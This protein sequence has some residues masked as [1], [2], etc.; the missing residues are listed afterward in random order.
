MTSTYHSI[1]GAMNNVWSMVGQPKHINNALNRLSQDQLIQLSDNIRDIFKNSEIL[2]PPVLC[3]IGSQSSGKSITLNGL[4]GI[5]ILPNGKS[6]V[7]RTPIHLRLIHTKDSKIIYVDFFDN[8]DNQ[9]II[10]SFQIDATQTSSKDHNDQLIPIRDEIMKLTEQRAGRSKNVV[11]VPIDIRIRS[12]DVPNLSIIDLPGLTNIALTDE[13][14]PENIKE[15]IEQ[16]LIRYIKNPRTIILSI[17]PATID[18]ESDMGLGLIKTY[19]P[20]FKRTIGVITKVDMLKDSNVEQYLSGTISRNLRLG[21]GYYAVRN[22]SSEEIKTMTVRDGYSLEQKYFNETEPYKSSEHIARTGSLNLGNRLSEIL[23]AH[24]RECLPIVMEEIKNEDKN[25]TI[26]LDEIGRDYPISEETKCGVLNTLISNFNQEYNDAINQRGSGYNTGAKIAESF[27]KFDRNME[28]L[29]P[30]SPL[31]FSDNVINNIVCEYNGIHMPDMVISTGVIEKCI[32][33]TMINGK[34]MEP[35][36]IINEPTYQCIKEVQHILMDLIDLILQRDKYSRFPKLCTRIREIMNTHIIP[37]GCQTIYS[38]I[39]DFLIEETKCIWTNDHKF[40]CETL[41]NMF[42]KSKNGSIEPQIVR[43]ALSGYFDVIRC[44]A[45]HSI[46]KKINAF[47]VNGVISHVSNI[48]D[49]L[50]SHVLTKHN[51][52]QILEENKE[53]VIKRENLMKRKEKIESAKNMIFSFMNK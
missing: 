4:T 50:M 53:K 11:D 12:P 31:V 17:I 15:N 49:G 47:F 43:S 3:V 33:G 42:N 16:M 21:Y 1:T 29:D 44:I 36:K 25:I 23:L 27:C 8:T 35:L 19:D 51:L 30:F 39:D 24:L 6:I 26:Q 22:R 10:S 28:K 14:Q 7:T 9:K 18:V 46:R 20:E 34:I 32:Q 37:T 5:D 38:K 52:S 13:G 41:P 2:D 45:T 48:S 40:R